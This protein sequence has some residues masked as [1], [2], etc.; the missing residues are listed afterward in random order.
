MTRWRRSSAGSW[1][2]ASQPRLRRALSCC[3]GTWALKYGF[4]VLARYSTVRFGARAK[5]AWFAAIN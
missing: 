1:S 4:L 2:S 3:P 5:R